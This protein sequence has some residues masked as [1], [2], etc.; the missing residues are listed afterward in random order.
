[1]LCV[2]VLDALERR[3][4]LLA[5]LGQQRRVAAEQAG[6]PRTPPAVAQ[7]RVDEADPVR[8]HA[9]LGQRELE[10]LDVSRLLV[11]QRVEQREAQ[12]VL[13]PDPA[14]AYPREDLAPLRRAVVVAREPVWNSTSESGSSK[15]SSTRSYGDVVA[16]M[17]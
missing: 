2:D 1:M 6:G 10:T 5:E 9:V 11:A 12:L 16:S 13:A 14:V 15:P 4:D 7:Q 17:A 3:L 8:R